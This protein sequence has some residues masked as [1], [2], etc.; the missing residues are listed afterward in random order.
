MQDVGISQALIVTVVSMIV[1]FIVLI[2]VAYCISILKT[3]G[4]KN[5]KEEVVDYINL[6]EAKEDIDNKQV[7]HEEVDKDEELVAV[8]AAAIAASMGVDIPQIRIN[9]IRRLD[10]TWTN[11]ARVEKLN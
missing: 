2:I 10:N 5:K 8:I 4:Q 11:T 3:F 1:V 7:N 9:K 6:E